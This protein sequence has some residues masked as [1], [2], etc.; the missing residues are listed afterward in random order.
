MQA[1]AENIFQQDFNAA[2]LNDKW[3]TKFKVHGGKKTLYLSAIFD[4]YDRTPVAFV[5]SHRNNNR[6]VFKTFD[7]AMAANPDTKQIFHGDRGFQYTNATV[8]S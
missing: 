8:Q 3:A 1:V 4:L 2:T 7:Q 5:L 6:L